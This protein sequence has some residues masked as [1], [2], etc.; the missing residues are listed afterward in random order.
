MKKQKGQDII[1]YALMLAVVVGIGFG[2]YTHVGIG[3]HISTVFNN[4][5]NLLEEVGKGKQTTFDSPDDVI[6]RLG[7]G[8]YQGLAD[9]LKENPTGKALDI[10]SNSAQGQ[11][12]ARKLN[13][14][15]K[16]GDG[17][18]ARVNTNGYF[19]VSYYSA[20]ANKGVIFSQLQSDYNN[21]PNKSDKYG[22]DSKG[23]YKTTIQ[24]DEGYYYPNGNVKFYN[25][26]AAHLE[27][28]PN[29]SGMSIYP[30]K[31]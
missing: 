17:W 22:K 9:L 8:R 14:Q 6:K 30:G 11:E 4:A 29:G 20:A 7:E 31:T 15:N 12:L 24:I 3:D 26:T 19:V 10:S 25:N 1:E 2:L 28:S 21:T 13:I 5:G 18:Y 27:P 16:E 23:Y